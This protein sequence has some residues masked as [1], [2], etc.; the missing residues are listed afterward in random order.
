MRLI[1]ADALDRDGWSASRTYPKDNLTIVYETK[2]L[3]DFPTADVPDPVKHGKWVESGLVDVIECSECGWIKTEPYW[4]YCPNCGS[5]M[6]FGVDNGK[7]D[8]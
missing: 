7:S 5:K 8:L 1:D 3:T 6:D 4:N 2:K